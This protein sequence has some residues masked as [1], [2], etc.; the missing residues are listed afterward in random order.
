ML[1]NNT[2]GPVDESPDT[3]ELSS[4]G[5]QHGNGNWARLKKRH[6]EKHMDCFRNVTIGVE[7]ST[8]IV[9]KARL[10]DIAGDVLSY[11]AWK[12]WFWIRT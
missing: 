4:T 3:P 5:G 9:G 11:I 10:Y 6:P 7:L 8:E 2:N 1:G 12:D